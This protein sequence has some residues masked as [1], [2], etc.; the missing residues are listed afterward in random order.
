LS[1]HF[2]SLYP[3]IAQKTVSQPAFRIS[4]SGDGGFD[5]SMEFAAGYQAQVKTT[6][7]SQNRKLDSVTWEISDKEIKINKL[8]I[9]VICLE[10]WKPNTYMVVG[11][12][13]KEGAQKLPTSKYDSSKRVVK[14]SHLLH[15]SGCVEYL[16][17]L[18]NDYISSGKNMGHK[19]S[20]QA[21][22]WSIAY[23]TIDENFPEVEAACNQF[24]SK[25]YKSKHDQRV[26]DANAK[27]KQNKW[28]EAIEKFTAL[29]EDRI[30][31]FNQKGDFETGTLLQ[32]NDIHQGEEK[33]A[34]RM[35]S[36]G[37]L[38][39]I[40]HIIIC[41]GKLAQWDKV[42]E[43]LEKGL[44][45]IK[46]ND[47]KLIQYYFNLVHLYNHINDQD[48]KKKYA[49]LLAEKIRPIYNL[50]PKKVIK[51]TSF[52]PVKFNIGLE[53]SIEQLWSS[54]RSVEDG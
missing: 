53:G 46:D 35:L 52:T 54:R 29:L 36:Q 41:Y 5:F 39:I 18:Q 19:D 8:F 42:V 50:T 24:F 10:T 1:S 33:F 45:F 40:E 7:I 9:F 2:Y 27:F 23:N 20:S 28:Q 14:L 43:Y 49:K 37:I 11:F 16:D 47:E 30:K 21:L 6:Q 26:F 17:H 44:E 4:D 13:P 48:N 34:P 25:N 12:L 3:I 32:N 51:F 31:D 22:V 15:P 38:A